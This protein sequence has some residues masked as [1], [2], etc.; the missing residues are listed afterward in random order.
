[1]ASWLLQY[2]YLLIA[3]GLGILLVLSSISRFIS[4]TQ[5]QLD[6]SVKIN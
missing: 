3:F 4:Q 2:A 1:M 5:A 6:H